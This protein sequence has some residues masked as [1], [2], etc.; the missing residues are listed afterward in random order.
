MPPM[1]DFR[2]KCGH[3]EN[4]IMTFEKYDE[5][6]SIECT[7]CGTE[8]TKD[9]REICS[10]ITAVNTGPGKGNFNSGDFT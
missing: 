10:N 2:C 1:Y 8:L 7:E 9:D 4:P 6:E 3:L 5:F